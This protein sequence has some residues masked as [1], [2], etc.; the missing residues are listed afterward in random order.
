MIFQMLTQMV[1]AKMRF[2]KYQL[3]QGTRTELVKSRFSC[4]STYQVLFFSNARFER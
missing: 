2:L 3:T 4:S 1:R